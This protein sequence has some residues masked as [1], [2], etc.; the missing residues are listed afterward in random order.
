MTFHAYHPLLLTS[1]H[2]VSRSAKHN[3]DFEEIKANGEADTNQSVW[4]N[5]GDKYIS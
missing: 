2:E 4:G 1:I 3:F 5:L